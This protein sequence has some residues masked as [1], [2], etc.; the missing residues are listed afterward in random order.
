MRSIPNISLSKYYQIEKKFIEHSYHLTIQDLVKKI[1][2]EKNPLNFNDQL[3][4][5][6]QLYFEGLIEKDSDQN[7]DKENPWLEQS[8]A[9][10]RLN[11]AGK[12]AIGS[13][14]RGNGVDFDD[15]METFLPYASTILQYGNNDCTAKHRHAYFTDYDEV[16]RFGLNLPIISDYIGDIDTIAC[17]ASGGFEPSYLLMDM[18]EKEELAVMRYSNNKN[19]SEVRVPAYISKNYLDSQIKGKKVLVVE[20]MVSTGISLGQVMKFVSNFKPKVNYGTSVIGNN[21]A[22]KLNANILNPLQP[23]LCEKIGLMSYILRQ[24]GRFIPTWVNTP[25]LRSI[26][27]S[28]LS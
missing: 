21:Y 15:I 1:E 22:L 23:F 26:S 24:S 20:D 9:L 12:K 19:D 17:V 18:M 7:I 2:N 3:L 16:Q 6:S 11:L 5:I 13:F 27:N 28:R 10:S 14:Y 25:M 4:A 8:E